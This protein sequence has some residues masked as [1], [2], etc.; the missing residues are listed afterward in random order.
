MIYLHFGDIFGKREGGG[1]IFDDFRRRRGAGH[2]HTGSDL[3]IT[4]S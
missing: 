4:I 2:Q 1:S 3:K